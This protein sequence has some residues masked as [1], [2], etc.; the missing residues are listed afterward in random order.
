MRKLKSV[1]L[2]VWTRYAGY[3]RTLCP[4]KKNGRGCE[5]SRKLKPVPGWTADKEKVNAGFKTHHEQVGIG[6]EPTQEMI[7]AGGSYAS[8]KTTGELEYVWNERML[9]DSYLV[10]KCPLFK[11][12]EV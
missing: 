10:R 11:E 12:T 5:W 1:L 2:Q 7:D 3:A 8:N 6:F 4:T 9:A